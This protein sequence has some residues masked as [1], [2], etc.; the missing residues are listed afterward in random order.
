[1]IQSLHLHN[2]KCFADQTI[3]FAP[4]TLLSGLNGQG[5]SSVLQALLLLRQSYQQNLLPGEGLALNGDLVRI[6]T[7]KD[8][9]YEDARDDTI[10][11]NLYCTDDIFGKWLFK[12][13]SDADVLQLMTSSDADV[14]PKMFDN[15]LFHD[16]FQYLQA[17]RLGPRV[18]SEKSDF[19]VRQHRQIG[20]RGEYSA[21]FLSSFGRKI[22]SLNGVRH[23]KA[24][25][26]DLIDQTEAW[27]HEITPNTRL[28]HIQ[29]PGTDLV[30]LQYAFEME[31]GMS[32]YYRSTNVGFGLAYTLPVLLA[33]LSASE[34]AL[35]LFENPEAHLHPKGQFKLGELMARAAN[36]GVQIVAE[37]HSDHILNG[38]RVAVHSG[39]LRPDIVKLHFFERE[40]DKLDT[41]VISPQID[42]N[43]RIDQWPEGFFDE[44]D[45]TL[46]ALLMPKED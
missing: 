6:G 27:L 11:F 23:P 12:Y 9:L 37:T 33:I 19:Y 43:G 34:N 4:L 10:G 24:I 5:K 22:K 20:T 3:Q 45:K 26:S 14:L 44:W 32:S 35:L 8:A 29:H 17:E 30:S 1:M 2:F 28:K 38:V 46:E 21:D 18:S 39:I 31:W 42:H 41:R 15:H 13:D 40:P 16:D 36:C 25:S 7:A